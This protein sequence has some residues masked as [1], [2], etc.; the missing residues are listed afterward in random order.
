MNIEVKKQVAQICGF[1]PQNA[2]LLQALW[3]NYG[4]LYRVSNAGNTQSAI[5]KW[6][7]FNQPKNHPKG[8][9]NTEGHQRKIKSYQMEAN[10]YEKYSLGLSNHVHLPQYLGSMAISN[11]MLM[12]LS[13][14]AQQNL[15]PNLPVTP[16]R[17]KAVLKWL[18]NFH[19]YFLN[20]PAKKIWPIGSYW[21]L[22]TR[23]KE[24][25]AMPNNKLKNAAKEIDNILHTST[26]STIIHGDAKWANFCFSSDER[27][28]AGL[29]FQYVGK[30]CGIID[31]MYFI[32][33]VYSGNEL[34][35]NE[36][37]LLNYYFKELQIITER[38]HPDIDFN[39][40]K[41]EW[42]KLYPFAW[43][44]FTRFLQGWMP[45]HNKLTPYAL[46]LTKQ[47]LSQI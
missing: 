32:S 26:Y 23:I 46:K 1:Y 9:G 22:G 36:N 12:G 19:G 30:G 18:A 20:N 11:G 28:V 16:T 21:H 39:L 40:L 6:I 2:I 42:I 27:E 45:N 33:S 38:L 34:E 35:F 10:F 3:S 25:E 37:E 14:L 13:D 43:A 41:T 31:V 24:W 47:A 29:D 5:V 17:V 7:D 44:D 4:G 15:F 8:W